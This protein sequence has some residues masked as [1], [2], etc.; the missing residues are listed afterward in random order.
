MQMGMAERTAAGRPRANP[1]AEAHVAALAALFRVRGLPVVH[2]HH[3]D[4]DPASP[5]RPGAAFWCADA[6]RRTG[7]G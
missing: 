4:A 7:A 1:H 5:F 6:L 3:D 2:V